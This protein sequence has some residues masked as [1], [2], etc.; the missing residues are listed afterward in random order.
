MG[1]LG[2]LMNSKAEIYNIFFPILIVTTLEL[3]VYYVGL[4]LSIP[5]FFHIFQFYF[6]KI[7]DNISAEFGVLLGVFIA[8]NSIIFLPFIENIFQLII[9]LIAYGIGGSIWNV[10]AW[11]LMGN[12]AK[13]YDIEGE[14]IGTYVSISKL[15][16]F[17]ATLASAYIIS[18]FGIE[19]TLAIFGISIILGTILVYFLF[20]P[21]FHHK[22]HKH[23]FHKIMKKHQ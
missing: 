9:L 4:F 10:N 6:G 1:L 18:K 11:V 21:I 5:I 13:K 2:I 16:V 7:G 20:Q 12:I 8:A 22:K 15:G 17:F 23:V 3:P 14:I 19:Q